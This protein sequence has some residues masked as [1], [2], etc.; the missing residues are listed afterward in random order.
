MDC[1]C[2]DTSSCVFC[3]HTATHEIYTYCHTLALHDALPIWQS[4]DHASDHCTATGMA[5]ADSSQR[6]SEL[7]QNVKQL[8]QAVNGGEDGSASG[9]SEPASG[10]AAGSA[11]GNA[12]SNDADASARRAGAAPPAIEI[13]GAVATAGPAPHA[14]VAG[15]SAGITGFV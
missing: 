15:A 12:G 6:I 1:R 8:K 9:R 3:N 14:D 2:C 13:E 11:A 4:A 7:E 5:V 10:T